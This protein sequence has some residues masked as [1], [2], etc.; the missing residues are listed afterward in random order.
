MAKPKTFKLKVK[1]VLAPFINSRQ[2]LILL[3]TDEEERMLMQEQKILMQTSCISRVYVWDYNGTLTDMTSMKTVA[4][5]SPRDVIEWFEKPF[6]GDDGKNPDAANNPKPASPPADIRQTGP[7][8]DSILIMFDVMYHMQDSRSSG[9]SNPGLTRSLKKS[10]TALIESRRNIV[11]VSHQDFVP[12]EL[13]HQI[14]VVRY[15]LPDKEWMLYLINKS[16]AM[17]LDPEQAE[18]AKKDQEML[19]DLSVDQREMLASLLLGFRGWEAENILARASSENKTKRLKGQTSEV[20]FDLEIVRTAK[21]DTIQKTD[22]LRI[23]LP[24][25][26]DGAVP[27]RDLIAGGGNIKEWFRE[28]NQMFLEGARD[29]GIDMPKGAIIFGPSGT[30]KDWTIE[31]LAK[32]VGYT[33]LYADLGASKGPNQGETHRGYRQIIAAAESQA[34]CFLV[35]SEWE[36]MM[37]GAWGRGGTVDTVQ[38]E[39]FA[40]FLNWM[41]YRTSK[42]FVWA[43]TN[44]IL[45]VPAEALRAQ[46]WDAM[47][48]LDMPREWER[49]ET[50]RV[51]LQRTRW[52]PEKYGIDVRE[53]A[54]KTDGYSN[55][56]VAAVVNEAIK[57]KLLRDGARSD[58]KFLKHQHL[59]EAL[60]KV[61]PGVRR[62]DVAAKNDALRNYALDATIPFANTPSRDFVTGQAK[63]REKTMESAAKLIFESSSTPAV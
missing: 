22:A 21:I 42:V 24:H 4:F 40:S 6:T 46:R 39:V 35:L 23:V 51:H 37:A 31:H 49:E 36:K 25:H 55:A 3:V 48:F 28:Q 41:Q 1:S 59:V 61:T 62:P 5:Q 15:P 33:T 38:S 11:M 60:T 27:E 13:D 50:F 34:P 47:W 10:Q 44:D 43:V 20:M 52:E 9:H 16:L 2:P 57:M 7:L 56:E 8:P 53:L 26:E 45:G 14:A 30:G 54:M 18:K 12:P 29:E 19:P 17:L 63:P 58:K 32:S